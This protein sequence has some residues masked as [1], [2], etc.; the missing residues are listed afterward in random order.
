MLVSERGSHN[1]KVIDFLYYYLPRQP[2]NFSTYTLPSMCI[3]YEGLFKAF[4]F[5][6]KLKTDGKPFKHSEFSI[7]VD[8]L[9]R[10][11]RGEY[12]KAKGLNEDQY[13]ILLAPGN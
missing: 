8:Q 13:L 9:V 10:K 3:G 12:R 11:A 1:E 2:S 6:S 4:Q 5:L 7:E